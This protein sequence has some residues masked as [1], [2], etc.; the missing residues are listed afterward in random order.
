MTRLIKRYGNRKLYDTEASAYVSLADVGMLVRKG[1]TVQVV[2]K[3]SG[4]DLTAQTLTQVILEE[5]KRGEHA[6]PTDF[7]HDM[8]RRGTSALDQGAS[9]VRGAVQGAVQTALPNG[10]RQTREFVDASLR[11]LQGT[12][13][14]ERAELDQL[15]DQLGSLET[16]LGRLLDRD[17]DEAASDPTDTDNNGARD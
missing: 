15:R 8:L 2:D 12:L 5:G 17:A 4:E 3:K 6:L 7:L 10:V 11:R 9:A 16:L 1:E 13:P 14:G